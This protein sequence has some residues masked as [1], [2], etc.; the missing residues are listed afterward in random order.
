LFL[1]SG[2][3][4]HLL[5]VVLVFF[6]VTFYLLLPLLVLAVIVPIAFLLFLP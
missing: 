3:G 4:L 6:L 5:K 2:S 1:L